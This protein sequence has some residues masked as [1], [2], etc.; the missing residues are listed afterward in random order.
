[1]WNSFWCIFFQ[2]QSFHQEKSMGQQNCTYLAVHSSYRPA[3]RDLSL[4]NK[5]STISELPLPIFSKLLWKFA[6]S[7][8]KMLT[9]GNTGWERKI[10]SFPYCMPTAAFMETSPTLHPSVFM[11]LLYWGWVET[12]SWYWGNE[13]LNLT[14]KTCHT[15]I[16][17]TTNPAWTNMGLNQGH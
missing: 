15:T 8:L 3:T 13:Q 14:V 12:V 1:M 2:S 10:N 16:L 9:I 6:P 17:S 7:L 4:Q 5:E 11:Y